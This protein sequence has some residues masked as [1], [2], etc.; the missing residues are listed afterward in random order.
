MPTTV[1]WCPSPSWMSRATRVRSLIVASSSACA[2]K[3]RSWALATASSDRARCSRRCSAAR[4]KANAHARPVL[5]IC[6]SPSAIGIPRCA[7]GTSTRTT[8]AQA[9]GSRTTACTT[10]TTSSRVLPTPGPATPNTTYPSDQGGRQVGDRRHTSTAQHPP[11]ADHGPRDEHR[12][13]HASRKSAV[14]RPR[15]QQHDQ[16]RGHTQQGQRPVHALTVVPARQAVNHAAASPLVGSTPTSAVT[17]ERRRST[18]P[19]FS[20]LRRGVVTSAARPAGL[21]QGRSRVYRIWGT[22]ILQGPGGEG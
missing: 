9:S 17:A 4:T 18:G 8:P 22:T 2:L 14:A 21:R 6:R 11:V 5:T 15:L 20:G 19:R 16:Q 1:R 12:A 10:T 7:S 13:Q 3:S